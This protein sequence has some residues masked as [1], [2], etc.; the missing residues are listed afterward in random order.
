MRIDDEG[1]AVFVYFDA[2]L[3][4]NELADATERGEKLNGTL[5]LKCNREMDRADS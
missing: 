3:Y 5:E 1:F 4:A 2:Q